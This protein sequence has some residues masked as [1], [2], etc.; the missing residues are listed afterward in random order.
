MQAEIKDNEKGKMSKIEIDGPGKK[1]TF[2]TNERS[3]RNVIDW[4]AR[5]FREPPL[6]CQITS[7]DLWSFVETKM[8]FPANFP[9]HTQSVER[10]IKRVTEAGQHVATEDRRDG[11]VLAQLEACRVLPKYET[12]KDLEMLVNFSET[13]RKKPRRD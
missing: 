11:V 2:W 1:R 8:E 3:F 5:V 7:Q 6:T 13:Y 4:D 12:K 10:M 9:C